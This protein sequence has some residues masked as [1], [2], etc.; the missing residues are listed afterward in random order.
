MKDVV[1]NFHNAIRRYCIERRLVCAIKY[2]ELRAAGRDRRGHGYTEEA[3]STFPKYLIL[4]ATLEQFERYRPEEFA[5]L[6]DAKPFFKNVAGDTNLD[7]RFKDGLE[8]KAIDEERVLLQGFI[9]WQS[10]DTLP[11]V[12]P[13]FYRRVISEI[14]AKAVRQ[15][16]YEHWNVKDGYWFLLTEERPEQVEAFQ[17]RHFE[18]E[19]GSEKLVDML[20][21]GGV[22]RV[23]VLREGG[24]SY[25]LDA[26]EIE[27]YYYYSGGVESFWCDNNFDWII[28]ASHEG[29][30][31]IGGWL[32]ADVEAA[33]ANWRE[34]VW[35][36][37]DFE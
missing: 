5:S 23:W 37:W 19:V 10:E 7:E 13:L 6:E 22:T 26:S 29:S 17:D 4:D 12:E 3:L 15:K 1:S 31:T 24:P 25:E 9:E 20:A 32:L 28:Y 2:D 30:I 33:W 27:S 11:D 18:T 14:E 34:R 21:S 35:T 36:S 8:K 16:L